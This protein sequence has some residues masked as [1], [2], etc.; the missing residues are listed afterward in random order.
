MYTCSH[1]V[2]A[3]IYLQQVRMVRNPSILS[4]IVGINIM[5]ISLYVYIAHIVWQQLWVLICWQQ[6][7]ICRPRSPAPLGVKGYPRVTLRSAARRMLYKLKLVKWVI[8]GSVGPS[9]TYISEIWLK[10]QW[11]P[12]KKIKFENV[13]ANWGLAMHM[14]VCEMC[15][16]CFR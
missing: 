4:K 2:W 5:I 1:I 11:F 8:I 15:R 13:I 3:L 9:E 7:R 6:A 10:I 14:F 12:F 16:H